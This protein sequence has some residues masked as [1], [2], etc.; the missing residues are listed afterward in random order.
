MVSDYLLAEAGIYIQPINYPTV[1][2]GTER[3]RITP[4][5]FHSDEQ[6]DR[7]AEA[8]RGAWQEFQLWTKSN[9]REK[10]PSS[11]AA[12]WKHGRVTVAPVRCDDV[13]RPQSLAS[14]QPLSQRRQEN[15]NTL[16]LPSMTAS[17]ISRCSGA[18]AISCHCGKR[19][20][21]D[22]RPLSQ[23]M[24]AN[25]V[26]VS[27][28]RP[29]PGIRS[30]PVLTCLKRPAVYDGLV[31]IRGTRDLYLGDGPNFGTFR[32]RADFRPRTIKPEFSHARR[33]RQILDPARRCRAL[34]PASR[35]SVG[36][37][38][39]PDAVRPQCRSL[40]RG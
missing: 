10:T 15:P 35:R 24:I 4:T 30:P 27:T 9:A 26:L 34:G 14:H 3:L 19:R 23:C 17:S 21:R 16:T 6:I 32:K 37:D 2:R 29:C 5:P 1:P 22:L 20:M 28:S 38:R 31:E 8:L 33:N 36:H 18:V 40:R 39:R 25:D 13:Y 7:L 12:D 11:T